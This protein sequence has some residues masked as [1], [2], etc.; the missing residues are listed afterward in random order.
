MQDV[1]PGFGALLVG[2]A[3]QRR[4]AEAVAL[5]R[6]F[7]HIGGV[8]DQF[9]LETVLTACLT[10]GEVRAPPL[11][12]CLSSAVLLMHVYHACGRK[13][14]RNTTFWAMCS[15]SLRRTERMNNSTTNNL[16]FY[17]FVTA[18]AAWLYVVLFRSWCVLYL[19]VVL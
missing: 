3:R 1:L 17:S 16:W 8:P 18:A 14:T 2:Y 19:E 12:R 13:P 10:S 5:L 11:S 7:N 6:R 9:M 15:R 4:C